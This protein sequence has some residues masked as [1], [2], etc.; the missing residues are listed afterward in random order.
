VEITPGNL[1]D[2]NLPQQFEVAEN[3]ACAEHHAAQR[4]GG[5]AP[6][7]RFLPGFACP[8]F[9]VI[10]T[11]KDHDRFTALVK[12]FNQLLDDEKQQPEEPRKP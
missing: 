5:D 1:F 4:V 12:E 7:A 11:E 10:A 2:R 6:A 8:D 9:S 3:L